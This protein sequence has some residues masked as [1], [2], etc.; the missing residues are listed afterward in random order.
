[1]WSLRSK[2]Q[3]Q[4]RE[5]GFATASGPLRTNRRSNCAGPGTRTGI[6]GPLVALIMYPR[7]LRNQR[8]GVSAETFPAIPVVRRLP[9]EISRKIIPKSALKNASKI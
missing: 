1:M 4:N 7:N 6:K 5:S 8:I 3:K 2:L 9:V